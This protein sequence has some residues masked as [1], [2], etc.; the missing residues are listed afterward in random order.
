M[1]VSNTEFKINL[2]VATFQ[3]VIKQQKPCKSCSPSGT[4]IVWIHSLAF[5]N[6]F[7]GL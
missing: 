3:M 5:I 2:F 6:S 1:L 4:L 7:S